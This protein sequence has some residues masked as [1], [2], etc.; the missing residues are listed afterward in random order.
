MISTVLPYS[1]VGPT[2]PHDGSEINQKSIDTHNCKQYTG[3]NNE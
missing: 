3:H 1:T 2:V